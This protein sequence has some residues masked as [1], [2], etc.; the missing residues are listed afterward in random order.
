MMIE[1][2]TKTQKEI[3]EF[4][5]ERIRQ[6]METQA[7]FLRCRTLDDI[8]ETQ[9]RFFRTAM[10]QYA[11]EATKLLKIGAEMMGPANKAH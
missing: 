4:L 9:T 7:E 11:A 8:R 3:S 5:S 6:D 1:S 2:F 10:D